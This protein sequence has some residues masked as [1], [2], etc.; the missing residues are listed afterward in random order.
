MGR[1]II[2]PCTLNDSPI[3][4][5]HNN[6]FFIANFFTFIC[7]SGMQDFNYVHSNCFEITIELTCCKYPDRSTLVTEWENNKESMLKY[8]EAVHLGAKGIVTNQITGEPIAN[9]AIKVTGNAKIIYTTERGEYWRLLKP[10]KHEI[11]VSAKGYITSQPILV[12][13][14]ETHYQI[15][16]PLEYGDFYVKLLHESDVDK[17]EQDQKENKHKP[18]FERCNDYTPEIQEV[19]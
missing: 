16:T 11:T 8:I 3:I 2:S 5:F 15:L 7:I 1:G 4:F 13:I 18:I 19:K 10:G 17:I 9:A 6:N 14:N 12:N